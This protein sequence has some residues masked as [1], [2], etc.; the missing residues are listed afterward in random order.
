MESAGMTVRIDTGGNLIGRY[1]GEQENSA[2]AI[3]T[4]SHIDTVF[5]GGRFDGSLGTIAGSRSSACPA[6][7]QHPALPS[8]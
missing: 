3:A 8:L 2:P 1:A 7:K 4:G 5:S 6:R